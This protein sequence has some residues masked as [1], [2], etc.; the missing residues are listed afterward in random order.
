MLWFGLADGVREHSK[1][2][3]VASEDFIHQTPA[4]TF[5]PASDKGHHIKKD[6]LLQMMLIHTLYRTL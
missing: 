1:E 4:E 6:Y 2:T 5:H 3:A